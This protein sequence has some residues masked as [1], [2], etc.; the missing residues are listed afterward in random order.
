MESTWQAAVLELA[1]GARQTLRDDGEFALYRVRCRSATDGLVRPALRVAPLK[2]STDSRCGPSWIP[3]GPL[4]RSSAAIL[5]IPSRGRLERLR[6]RG[7]NSNND[8]H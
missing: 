3:P 8:R 6:P 2:W 4:C 1:N 7:F 5:P